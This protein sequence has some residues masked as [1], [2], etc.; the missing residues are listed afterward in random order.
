MPV[1]DALAGTLLAGTDPDHA[2]V[3]A[4]L[5]R[6]RALLIDPQGRDFP[7]DANGR[8]Q[9][10]HPVDASVVMALIML[11]GKIRCSPDTGWTGD[12]IKDFSGPRGEA[13]A[14]ARVR[15]ALKPAIDRADIEVVSIEYDPKPAGPFV[16]V[17]YYNNRLLPRKLQSAG[18]SL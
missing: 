3:V 10:L 16:R 12:Q 13:D 2:L 5:A 18:S 4:G 17:Q 9:D 1:D 11:Q 6:P 8:Y 7:L 15:S 14:K